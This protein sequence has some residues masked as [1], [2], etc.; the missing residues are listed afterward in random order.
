MVRKTSHTGQARPHGKVPTD[1]ISLDDAGVDLR[2]I[3]SSFRHL[4]RWSAVRVSRC[5]LSSSLRF[6]LFFWVHSVRTIREVLASTDLMRS[7]ETLDE[8]TDVAL[9][10]GGR[11]VGTITVLA[12]LPERSPW[13]GPQ[14]AGTQRPC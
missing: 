6:V 7:H 11:R 14:R 2:D 5:H 10:A 9:N 13:Q 4:C 12:T 1:Y 8:E 3:A